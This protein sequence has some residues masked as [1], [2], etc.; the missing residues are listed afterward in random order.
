MAASGETANVSMSAEEEHKHLSREDE[1]EYLDLAIAN[2]IV[3]GNS[4]QWGNVTKYFYS[5]TVLKYTVEVLV[6]YFSSCATF[7]FYSSIYISEGNVELFSAYI[8][9]TV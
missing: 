1:A 5:S 6:L 4:K 9:V 3:E 2:M 8:H 7:Y